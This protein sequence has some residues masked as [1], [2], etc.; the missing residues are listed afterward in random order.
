MATMPRSAAFPV[1]GGSQPSWRAVEVND[2]V[3]IASGG[4]V[5]TDR[6]G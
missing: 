6:G 3:G 4:Y 5:V 2:E 1:P